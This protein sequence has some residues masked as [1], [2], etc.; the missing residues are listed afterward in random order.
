MKGFVS[1]SFLFY[2]FLLRHNTYRRGIKDYCNESPDFHVLSFDIQDILCF[3]NLEQSL[4]FNV[5]SN[6]II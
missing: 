6:N 3:K 2:V 5:K 4:R 1:I